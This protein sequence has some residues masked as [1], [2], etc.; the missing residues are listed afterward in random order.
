MLHRQDDD[1]DDKRQAQVLKRAE[2]GRA[3]AAT[4]RVDTD[5]DEAEA[6]GEDD[7]ARD[8]GREETA[9]RLQEKAEHGLEQA[10]DNRST[11]NGTVGNKAAA[12][13][14]RHG[15]EH[16]D[17]SRRRSHNDRNPAANRPD[18]EKLD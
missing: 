9:Q 12:H 4:E 3:V 10:A 7:G 1:K 15:V 2:I 5:A 17:E 14:G 6:N 8:D 13:R 16:A 11:H 18:T